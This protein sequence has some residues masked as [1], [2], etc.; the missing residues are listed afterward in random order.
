MPTAK[1]PSCSGQIP[2]PLFVSIA[3]LILLASGRLEIWHIYI[4]NTITGLMNAFQSPAAAVSVGMM[5][6]KEKYAR[7]S[8]LNSFS[9]SLIAVVTPML[10]AF[11]SSFW[12]LRGVLFIDMATF[13]FAFTALLL[14]IKIP[15]S[16]KPCENKPSGVLRGCKE[17]FAF[18]GQHK[19]LL[20][21][22][23]SMAMLNFFSRLTY[24]NIL[25]AMILARSGGQDTVLGIV[26][27]VLGLGGVLGG[28]IVSIGTPASQQGQAHLCLGGHFLS[29]WRPAHGPGGKALSCGSWP[30]W[31]RV[32][33]SP[34]SAQV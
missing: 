30:R 16:R 3:V 5:V 24:E 9:S 26:S 4:V 15:E 17:G 11:V 2:L 8:G 7:V 10:A 29:V 6:P 25:P 1:S 34:L 33:P 19:G 31:R 27:G 14:L 13:V 21:L 23:L 18:L 28:L 32:S 22:M 12:G 20:Y